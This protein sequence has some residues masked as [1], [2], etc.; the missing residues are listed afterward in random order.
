MEQVCGRCGQMQF[1]RLPMSNNESDVRMMQKL[2]WNTNIVN[3]NEP[4]PTNTNSGKIFTQVFGNKS[5]KF[6]FSFEK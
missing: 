3:V 4:R 2:L 1:A 5:K 6:N